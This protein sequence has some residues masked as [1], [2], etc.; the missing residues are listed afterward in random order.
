MRHASCRSA[1]RG[2]QGVLI[3]LSFKRGESRS[4]FSL[5]RRIL[6][7]RD[8]A[9]GDGL[10][11]DEAEVEVDLGT[12]ASVKGIITLLPPSGAISRMSPAPKSWKA[13]TSPITVPSTSRRRGRRDRPDRIVL[14]LLGQRCAV[15]EE[16]GP[17]EE[18]GSVPIGDLLEADHH[19][20]LLGA[21]RNDRVAPALGVGERPVGA[22]ILG[23]SVKER[24]RTSPLMP[25]APPI[26]ARRM[27]SRGASFTRWSPIRRSKA[28]GFVSGV[29]RP[30]RPPRQ[31]RAGCGR[32][33]KRKR[34][35]D[36]IGAP[37]PVFHV[38]R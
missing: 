18:F 22:E 36:R 8:Q 1:G 23:S 35:P 12:A 30:S 15:D 9:G 25:W 17:V 33:R 27:L 11:Q 14:A 16:L 2:D 26:T 24:T 32:Q 21:R 13:T 28:A 19:D 10:D 7:G 37:H 20:V 5:A 34:R 31:A 3:A 4:A 29:S 38:K 6:V